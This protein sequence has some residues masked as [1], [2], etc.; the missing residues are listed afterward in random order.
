LSGAVPAVAIAG[1]TLFGNEL[2]FVFAVDLNSGKILWRTEGLH[3]LKLLTMQDYTRM[4]D[5]SRFAI[6]ADGDY[7]WT[8][9]RDL[10]DP[11]MV[12]PY[13]LTCRRALGGEVVW[14]TPDLAD[15]TML[16]LNGPP[17]V[18][19]GK[20]FVAAKSQMNPQGGQRPAQQFV[21]AIQ[22]HDGKVLW[23]TEV[24][25]FRQG[26]RFWYYGAAQQEPQP[27]L[28]HRGG[29]AYVD[30]H[31]GILARLDANAGEID[32]G[33]G[34]KTDPFQ[35]SY[36]FFY[37]DEAQEP[38][39]ASGAPLLAAE[40]LLVKGVQSTRVAAVEPNRMKVLWE[41]PVAKSSRVIGVGKRAVFLGGDELSAIDLKTRALMW[42][43]RLPGDSRHERVL[44]RSDGLWQ[45]TSRGIFELDPDTGRVRQMFRGADLGSVGG[46]LLLT[47]DLLLAVSNRTV[48][49]YPRRPGKEKGSHE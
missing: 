30:T 17:I 27:R 23:K 47:D 20:L 32:W 19:D 48:T 39:S 40:S 25:T 1:S 3:H 10:K 5:A 46:D 15:Y 7:V 41:R 29:A 44:V 6:A 49:A 8:L 31:L 37:F 9:A 38:K 4:V 16:D 26:Q 12:G 21:L 2:G 18:A 24:A 35:S 22:P 34:Y 13:T 42:A 28:V 43:S 11:N 14:Q 33:Y 36:R 45:L